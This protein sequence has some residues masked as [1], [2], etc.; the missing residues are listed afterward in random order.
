MKIKAP[1][2]KK[3]FERKFGAA[4]QMRQDLITGKWVVIVP[5]REKR[6]SDFKVAGVLMD[7]KRKA[8]IRPAKACPFDDM[9]KRFKEAR[10]IYSR[11]GKARDWEIMSIANDFPSFFQGEGLNKR[12]EGIFSLQ[13][14]VGYNEVIVLRDHYKQL[15]DLPIVRIQ[16][17]L[18]TY[19]E[20]YVKLM[21]RKHVNYILIMQNYGAEAGASLIHPHSQLFA[22]PIISSDIADELDGALKYYRGNEA[23]VYC[24]ISNFEMKSRERIVYENDYFLAVCPFAS[25]LPY[26]I[27]IIHKGHEPY[28][29]RSNSGELWALA[30]ALKTCL[31]KLKKCLNDPSY[32][33]YIHT[34]PCD[35][36]SHEYYHWHLK[37]MP[38]LS[39]FAG[40]ELGTGVEVN[41]MP[42]ERAAALLRKM[43]C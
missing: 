41:T 25:R 34:A 28:F 9:E 6:P 17:L 5:G 42:P 15:A 27:S 38:R 21:N 20:R 4:P 18:K 13:D 12:T 3:Y 35:G 39:K 11:T 26:E 29:E 7:A 31:L 30:D 24:T 40:F 14:A 2:T 1:K 37:I 19:K 33:Y 36:L 23:C 8:K 10:L 32:N 43:K 22:I 16:E